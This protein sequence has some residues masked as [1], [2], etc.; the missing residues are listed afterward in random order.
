MPDGMPATFTGMIDRID[1]LPSGGIE[2]IDYKT[3]K[4]SSQ[5]GVQESLQL[6]IYALACR[7][8]LGLGTPEKVTLYFTESATRMSTT[9]T[10]EQLDEARDE[11]VRLGRASPLRRLRG[12]AERRAP[13]GAAIT[14]RCARAGLGNG[15]L[16]RTLGAV[17]SRP[18]RAGGGRP[19]WGRTHWRTRV[20]VETCTQFFSQKSNGILLWPPGSP[21]TRRARLEERYTRHDQLSCRGL[22]RSIPTNTR[23]VASRAGLDAS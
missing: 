20:K 13:A 10:D 14:R 5:K 15:L 9:R 7:D 1:R 12:H 18:P 21:V 3:G 16:V 2:V 19:P 17:R 8:A 11:L 23:E 4:L 6:S 22:C